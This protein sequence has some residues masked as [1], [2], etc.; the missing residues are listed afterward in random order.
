MR[1]NPYHPP[2]YWTHLARAYLHQGRFKEALDALEQV[3]KPRLDD[4]AYRIAAAAAL[5]DSDAVAINVTRL[6]KEF[7]D[8]SVEEFMQSQ[9]YESDDYRQALLEPLIACIAR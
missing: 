4:L 8:F 3:G 6:L 7:P 9:P 1:L 2:R 5:E